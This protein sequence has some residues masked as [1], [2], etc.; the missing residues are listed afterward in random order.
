MTL[1]E[2]VHDGVTAREA[3]EYCG[4]KINRNNM[5]CCPFHDD[6]T[7][8]MKIDNHY[9]CF[10]C[11][12]H[13][14]SIDFYSKYNNCSKKDAAIQLA[15]IF[16]IIYE[17]HDH[18][19]PY[20]I[21]PAISRIQRIKNAKQQRKESVNTFWKDIS[22]YYHTLQKQMEQHAP[23]QISPDNIKWDDLYVEAAN[24]LP[25]LDYLMDEFLT[26]SPEEQD[27]IMNLYAKTLHRNKRT[28]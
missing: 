24:Q 9:Y 6:R 28:A 15:D 26:G 21:K 27:E 4:I 19:N 17:E 1:F 20:R 25:Y 5:A 8:S 11:G 16:H 13:G 3:A 2:S 23:I 14:D 12:E 7:P 18:H 10:G 22:D